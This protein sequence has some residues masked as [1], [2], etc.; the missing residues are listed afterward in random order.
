VKELDALI[1]TDVGEPDDVHIHEDEFVEI[2][3]KARLSGCLLS[4]SRCSDRIRPMRRI[5]VVCPSEFVSILNT[6]QRLAF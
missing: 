3:D 6:T 5:V 2:Q 4:S 1:F